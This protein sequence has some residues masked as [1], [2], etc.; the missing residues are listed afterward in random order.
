MKGMQSIR[1]VVVEGAIMGPFIC[2]DDD[3]MN[4]GSAQAF[5]DFGQDFR[6]FLDFL[7]ESGD[8]E[9]LSPQ[10]F[11]ALLGTDLA[12]LMAASRHPVQ[13][14]GMEANTLQRH[15]HEAVRV[16]QL[17]SELVGSVE[18]SLAW[19]EHAALPVFGGRTPH[20]LVSEGRTDDLVRYLSS[21]EAGF[22][23]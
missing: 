3:I 19:F 17:C 1:D 22:S 13:S 21:L 9:T 23:G 12:G 14:R 15:L 7:R 5:P 10:R 8:A 2:P 11:A 4:D 20:Q 16:I 18:Q 6:A